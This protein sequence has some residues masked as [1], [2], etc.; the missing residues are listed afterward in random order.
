MVTSMPVSSVSTDTMTRSAPCS[1]QTSSRN[2]GSASI[3][4]TSAIEAS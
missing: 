2:A 3:A 1:A 4:A